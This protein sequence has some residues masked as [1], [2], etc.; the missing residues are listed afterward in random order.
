MTACGAARVLQLVGL[1]TRRAGEF[2]RLEVP[3]P[4]RVISPLGRSLQAWNGSVLLDTPPPR[5][6]LLDELPKLSRHVLARV[7]D[8]GAIPPLLPKGGGTKMLYAATGSQS[9]AGVSATGRP[10]SRRRKQKGPPPRRGRPFPCES[11]NPVWTLQR[12]QIRRSG[13]CRRRQTRDPWPADAASC[14]ETL[15]HLLPLVDD[16]PNIGSNRRIG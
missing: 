12:L 15:D 2:L 13:P 14:N 16:T 11:A 1:G 7:H 10:V 3:C 8:G 5:F 4:K 9:C 6:G